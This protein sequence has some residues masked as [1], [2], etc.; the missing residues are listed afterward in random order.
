MIYNNMFLILFIISM[1]WT[2]EPASTACYDKQGGLIYCISHPNAGLVSWCFEPSQPQ[3]ITSGLNTNFTPS[4]NYS[5]HKS[6]YHKSC[7]FSLFFLYSAGTQHRNLLPAGWPILF[8]RPTQEQVLATANT[9]QNWERVW[10]NAGE[11]TRRVEISKEEIPGSKRNMYGY[12]L[13]YS[14]LYRENIYA[15][16]SHQMGL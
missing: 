1:H 10:K 12:I 5:F 6:S 3:R 7:F 8:S 4:P 9:R 14:R 2:G 15:L 11:W 13:T 16:C